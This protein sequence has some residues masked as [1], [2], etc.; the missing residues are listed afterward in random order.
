M[1]PH[2]PGKLCVRARSCDCQRLAVRCSHAVCERAVWN[3]GWTDGG[4]LE[5]LADMQCPGICSLGRFWMPRTACYTHGQHD[6]VYASALDDY[7]PWSTLLHAPHTSQDCDRA[8]VCGL[9]CEDE[10][11]HAFA[12][13]PLSCCSAHND[14]ITNKNYDHAHQST[15]SYNLDFNL[16]YHSYEAPIMIEPRSLRLW[17]QE[18][19]RASC[20][21][22][23]RLRRRRRLQ[24]TPRTPRHPS[25]SPCA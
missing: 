20:T 25:L 7:S 3:R 23:P 18:I 21:A 10:Y 6:D 12:R 4:V 5:R 17:S 14:Y 1:P 15:S 11:A 2:E 19:S 22:S 8:F 24:R 9:H 16:I 13:V